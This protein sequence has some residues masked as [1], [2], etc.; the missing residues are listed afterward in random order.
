MSASQHEMSEET[1]ALELKRLKDRLRTRERVHEDFG[2]PTDPTILAQVQAQTAA[3]KQL[4]AKLENPSNSTSAPITPADIKFL[5]SFNDVNADGR[6]IVLHPEIQALREKVSQLQSAAEAEKKAHAQ[7]LAAQQKL[8]E[9][10]RKALEDQRK[11]FEAQQ[12]ALQAQLQ[13]QQQQLREENARAIARAAEEA[14]A[15]ATAEA[16][17]K[18]KELEVKIKAET[19]QREKERE[20][21]REQLAQQERERSARE[22]AKRIAEEQARLERER[23]QQRVAQ[24]QREREETERKEKEAK[25]Q[26]DLEAERAKALQAQQAMERERKDREEQAGKDAEKAR[27]KLLE[28]AR[29]LAQELKLEQ[30]KAK[31]AVAAAAEEERKSRSDQ[32]P[33]SGS[34][35]EIPDA[36][37]A[38]LDARTSAISERDLLLQALQRM[39]DQYEKDIK[40]KPKPTSRPKIGRLAE[41]APFEV[42]EE[43][44]KRL[45][46]IR[47]P[48]LNE[49]LSVATTRPD[50]ETATLEDLAEGIDAKK[51]SDINFD[52][53]QL[54]EI[55]ITLRFHR[56]NAKFGL[57]NQMKRTLD[58]SALSSRD[59]ARG[60]Q[61]ENTCVFG[62]T[63]GQKSV[64]ARFKVTDHGF[65]IE[66]V[67][68]GSVREY[69]KLFETAEKI[70][71]VM[72]GTRKGYSSTIWNS[73]RKG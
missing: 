47:V 71:V 30:E 16:A 15:H 65:D 7:A 25:L 73:F 52:A 2:L 53:K 72:S 4:I 11:A 31:A 58:G 26:A 28:S 60:V 63:K 38:A 10:Q 68:E 35:P 29:A 57:V 12:A 66:D 21:E 49:L 67:R 40:P 17:R 13:T 64:V 59:G 48:L 22:E 23:E 55:S 44:I 19:E 9:D 70:G 56:L 61:S 42:V 50:L 51:R 8:V 6:V 54:S 69:Q 20:R 45:K 39:I 43:E 41:D 36:H 33:G 62:G 5:S 37:N 46:F 18:M 3:I 1:R 32:S 24:A 14:A 27:E 34:K